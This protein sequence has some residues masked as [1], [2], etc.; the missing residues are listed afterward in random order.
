MTEKALNEPARQAF[1]P[2]PSGGQGFMA[3]SD[4]LDK[5]L[6]KV[7]AKEVPPLS[8]SEKDAVICLLLRL[9]TV[10]YKRNRTESPLSPKSPIRLIPDDSLC[11]PTGF[12]PSNFPPLA[13]GDEG[14]FVG[15]LCPSP[16]VIAVILMFT[17]SASPGSARIWNLIEVF[18]L[19][20]D[21]Q[22][23]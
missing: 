23:V 1:P 17:K 2:R 12:D 10:L 9:S 21:S 11:N 20:A 22:A 16:K 7:V 15:S 6:H 14:G 19:S 5:C 4:T 13:K 18:L 3:L 8:A